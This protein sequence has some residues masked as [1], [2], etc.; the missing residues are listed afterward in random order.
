MSWT[1]RLC[2]LKIR[3]VEALT[4]EVTV[5]GDRTCEEVIKVK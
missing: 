2:L 5:F 1:E 4:P 3:Y